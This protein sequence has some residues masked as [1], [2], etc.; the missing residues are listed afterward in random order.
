MDAYIQYID[1][2][3]YF[4][5]VLAGKNSIAYTF[6]KTLGGSNIAVFSYYLASPF[7]LLLLFFDNEHIHTF[8]DLTVALKISLASAAFAYF[9]IHRFSQ[10]KRENSLL[11][12]LIS[13]GYGLCQYNLAQGSNIMWLDGVYMLPFILLQVYYLVRDGKAWKLSVLVGITIVFNWYSAGIDCVFTGIWILFE[14]GMTAVERKIAVKEAIKKL[15]LYV[16]AMILGVLLSAFL[17]LPTVGALK[18]STRGSLHFEDLK[19]LALT[20]EIPSLVQKYTYGARSELGSAAIF[21]GSLAIVLAISVIFNSKIEAKKRALM[22]GLFAVSLLTLYWNPLYVV[23]SLFQRVTSYQ[24]RYSYTAVF[25]VLFLALYSNYEILEK[26]QLGKLLKIATAISVSM[27]TLYYLKP[28]NSFACVYATAAAVIVETLFYV[29][30]KISQQKKYLWKAALSVIAV[31]D[32]ACNAN[33]LMGYYSRDDVTSYQQYRKEQEQLLSMVEDV[34]DTFYRISQTSNHG[35]DENNL[36]ANYNEAIAYNYASISGYTS[37]PDDVQR[38]F[39]DKMGYPINGENM[40]ITNDSILGADSLLGVKYILS[41]YTMPGLE[42]LQGE[43][44]GEKK[45]FYNP[46]ALPTAFTYDGADSEVEAQAENGPFEYQNSLYEQ[47]FGLSE[48]LY[49]PLQYTAVENE[50][51]VEVDLEVPDGE[52]IIV[53]GYIP[54]GYWSDDYIYVNEK[55]VTKYSCWLAPRVFYI[56][57]EDSTNCKIKIQGAERNFDPNTMQFYALDLDVLQ[58]YTDKANANKADNIIVKNGFVEATVQSEKGGNCLF[59]SVPIDGGWNVELN[60]EKAQT[61]SVG[62][63]LYSIQLEQGTNEI[64]MTYHVKYLKTGMVVSL[65][66]L[67]VL[68]V[69]VYKEKRKMS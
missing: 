14:L 46:Y 36:T 31:A 32:L 27:V 67:F 6:G 61:S 69:G 8:F 52:N 47:I 44:D 13:M 62:N 53:Y 21:C 4:K 15:F 23:F 45:A 40:C 38:E 60:G 30:G 50:N 68:C 19:N 64:K 26:E 5:D 39:L 2:F 51:G 9:G 33:F 7:N 10:V 18:K 25:V 42:E 66:A 59:L 34:G 41:S 35:I 12:V 17:F 37:S 48:E 54:C 3:S 55:F 56:P 11:L 20:G 58:K 1:F 63:C 65:L 28:V 16:R 57:I 29:L 49:K 22:G 24:Y 43:T